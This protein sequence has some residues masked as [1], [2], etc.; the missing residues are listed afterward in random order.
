MGWICISKKW[1]MEFKIFNIT[2][3]VT[4]YGSCSCFGTISHD[5][6]KLF[7]NLWFRWN[8]CAKTSESWYENFLGRLKYISIYVKAVLWCRFFFYHSFRAMLY[9][10]LICSRDIIVGLTSRFMSLIIKT[11]TRDT[12][13]LSTLFGGLLSNMETWIFGLVTFDQLDLN[14]NLWSNFYL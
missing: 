2:P 12:Q 6:M 1:I 9:I 5:G 13:N 3:F 10:R 7:F 11:T 8:Y 4:S 14:G